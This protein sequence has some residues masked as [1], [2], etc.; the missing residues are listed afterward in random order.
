MARYV[1]IYLHGEQQQLHISAIV[2]GHLQVV[3]ENCSVGSYTKRICGLLIWGWVGVKWARDLV[4]Q[5]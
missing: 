5:S 2:N 4:D 3:Y 1:Y